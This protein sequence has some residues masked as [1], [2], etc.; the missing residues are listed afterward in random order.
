MAEAMG[1]EPPEFHEDSCGVGLHKEEMFS[2]DHHTFDKMHWR[3][4]A[5][6][7]AL[8]QLGTVYGLNL[9]IK[10]SPE[11]ILLEWWTLQW[12]AMGPMEMLRRQA[13]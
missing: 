2:L 13:L 5:W 12:H 6:K 4:S 1:G 10:G 11:Q 9:Q 3:A 8:C 7:A